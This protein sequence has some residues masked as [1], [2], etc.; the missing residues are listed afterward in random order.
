M[1]RCC[2]ERQSHRTAI[3]VCLCLWD[4][5][6][7][8]CFF[9]SSLFNFISYRVKDYQ[10]AGLDKKIVDPDGG[11][12]LQRLQLEREIWS[13]QTSSSRSK[14]VEW[15]SEGWT[16]SL[17]NMPNFQHCYLFAHLAGEMD[18]NS[19][20]V[21][22]GAFKLNMKDTLYTKRAMCKRFSS[23]ILRTKSIVSLTAVSKH[24]WLETNYMEQKY[25]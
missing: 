6:D 16:L 23:T 17:E 11:I 12:H 14:R 8:Y 20:K 10:K 2:S 24:R 1:S 9:D 4:F 7:C 3:E 22:H 15:P 19:S 25:V 5:F 21:R 13:Q 18:C